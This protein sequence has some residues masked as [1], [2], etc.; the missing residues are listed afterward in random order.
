MGYYELW[1]MKIVWILSEIP[2][3]E[4]ML[5]SWS[6]II[7]KILYIK[8]FTRS[9]HIGNPESKQIFKY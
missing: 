1:K 4:Q 2:S 5:N 6:D 3:Q 9:T 7:F 8:P